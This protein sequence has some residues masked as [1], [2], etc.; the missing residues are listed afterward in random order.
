MV[1]IE[2]NQL[3]MKKNCFHALIVFLIL[4]SCMGNKCFGHGR[5]LGEK[6]ELM[7]SDF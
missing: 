6:N 3:D 4:V 1:F 2:I 7:T 5:A